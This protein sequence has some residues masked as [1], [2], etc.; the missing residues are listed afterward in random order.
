MPSF[1]T[2]TF[3]MPT[4]PSPDHNN[5]HDADDCEDHGHARS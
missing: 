1:T 5:D 4:F 2:P 3:T